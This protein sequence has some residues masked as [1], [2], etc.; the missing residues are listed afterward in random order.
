MVSFHR[1]AK[2]PDAFNLQPAGRS[3]SLTSIYVGF[4][5]TVL[6]QQYMGRI[7]VWI[8]EIS[9]DVNDKSQW[10]TCSYASPFAGATSITKNTHG[11]AWNNSQRSY[12]FWFVPPDLEN[13]VVVCFANGD[14]ARGLWFGCLYQQNMNHMVPGIPG[15]PS[16]NGLPVVEY[17]KIRQDITVNTA[18]GPIYTPLADQL[19]IQGLEKDPLRGT[20]TSGARRSQ[21]ANGVYGIL[22]PGANQFVMDDGADGAYI[23]L[24]TQSGTAITVSETDGS[25]YMISR[26][27]NSWMELGVDGS[28][29][30]YGSNNLNIRTQGI[31]NL[32]ADLDINIE[33]GRSIYMKAR[34][35]VNSVV[36]NAAPATA[37]D[38]GQI[39]TATTSSNAQVPAIAVSDTH[40]TI[41]APSNGITGEFV[42]G[43][44][45]T[46]IP[47]NNPT[48]D[49]APPT[50]AP[51]PAVPGSGAPVVL[52]GDTAAGGIA[53]TLATKYPGTL[54]NIMPNVLSSSLDST[55][56]S[57]PTLQNAQYAVVSVG[58][59][60]T[61]STETSAGQLSE[62]LVSIRQSLNAKYYIWIL[63]LDP[64]AHATVY[65]FATGVGDV[66]QAQVLDYATGGT[67]SA[68]L[69]DN[70]LGNIGQIVTPTPP[71][72][73]TST[74]TTVPAA[75]PN[76]LLASV[77]TN[78]DGSITYLN[79]TFASG[80][81][82]IVSN[83][84][85]I[86]GTLQNPTSNVTV[87][88]T[89]N[90][91]TAPG[92]IM[93]NANATM[94]VTSGSDMFIQSG[95]IMAR[96]SQ[97]NMFDYA[98]GSYDLAVGGY[99]TMQSNG[100]LS[101]GTTNN[102]LIGANRI[103]LNGPAP[104]AAKA[105][106]AALKP[107]DSQQ[108]DVL[109]VGP[110]SFDFVLKNTIVSQLVTHEPYGGHSAAAP[111]YRGHV[112]QGT[113]IDPNTGAPL[114]QGQVVGGQTI[115]LSINGTPNGNSPPGMYE[116]QG[117]SA[118][119][120]PQYANTGPAEGQVPPG[121]LQLSNAGAQFIAAFEGKKSTVYLDSANLPTIGIGHLLLAEE[122]AGNYV[123]I[124]GQKRPLPP[125]GGPLTDAEIV[126]LFRHEL[127]RFVQIVRTQ[128]KVPLSQTQF[129]MLVSFAYNV[130]NI[131]AL[132]AVINTNNYNVTDI[133][134]QF[135][136]AKGAVIKG[137]VRRRQAEAA[138]FSAGK[139]INPGG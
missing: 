72:N 73:I 94:H 10:F 134:M 102:M 1:T 69:A 38:S 5:K 133:F 87:P 76:G 104:Q 27:G 83:A 51:T 96:T 49:T 24:R 56:K 42:P 44:T 130:G 14:P 78:D 75:Q 110:G 119:G 123:I 101:I 106:P 113:A 92:V 121:T 67:N 37:A 81:Q 84:S 61:R 32:H 55:I 29:N 28:I 13:E 35:D 116:G 88:Q 129:D 48:S 71:D 122:K 43:M 139:I 46:G 127:E 68:Q 66:P 12:G 57:T 41:A 18:V 89:N 117:Y 131:N 8:P 86:T 125:Q 60:D 74:A 95:G 34:G 91:S 59:Y 118:S 77:S 124:A 31:L 62:S 53:A 79:V 16:T 3:T 20:S 21:P 6:D 19:K 54:T 4:V 93:F 70:V 97:S 111:G 64:T 45:I 47:W 36:L 105:A 39:V 109:V 11:P 33:A 120:Q 80:N 128:I 98:Y 132:A 7:Q 23:R 137:L 108:Q 40:V 103:D 85:V 30:I 15:D 100:L 99:L 138:N 136:H 114:L 17:N 58:D 112:D 2:T 82:S 22:T 126:S 135:V 107:I 63:P 90:N 26:D 9:G 115:P 25:I 65:G 52:V 50:P